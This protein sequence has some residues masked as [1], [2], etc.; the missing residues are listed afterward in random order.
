MHDT[1]IRDLSRDQRR[2]ACPFCGAPGFC[3]HS[4][5]QSAGAPEIPADPR[6]L[7]IV[8]S[9]ANFFVIDFS[10]GNALWHYSR[11]EVTQA[12]DFLEAATAAQRETACALARW[13]NGDGP[14]PVVIA[15]PARE[16]G[17]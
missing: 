17:R 6:V 3:L 1:T 10:G 13:C 2:A 15:F 16:G 4:T 12:L 5:P 9:L 14:E 8:L 7:R 11:E